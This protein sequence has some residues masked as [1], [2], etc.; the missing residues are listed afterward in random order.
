MADVVKVN[1]AQQLV[2][3]E[4]PTAGGGVAAPIGSFFQRTTGQLY[5]KTAAGNTAWTL[6]N[7]F[8]DDY[9]F[10]TQEARTLTSSNIFIVKT[11][12]VTPALTGSYRLNW[13]AI[14]D[15]NGA[16][17]EFRLFNATDAVVLHGPVIIQAT[18]ATER[19]SVGG[20]AGIVFAG[21]SKTIEIQFLSQNGVDVQGIQQARIE[22]WRLP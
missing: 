3:S 14:V 15:N 22:L 12:M 20:F 17:G 2:G 19:I 6:I 16:A 1:V 4:D 10:V 9:Q 18:S 21:V 8:G 13:T 5:Y 7:Q 11:Q